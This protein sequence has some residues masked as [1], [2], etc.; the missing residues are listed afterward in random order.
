MNKTPEDPSEHNPNFVFGG[1][2]VI[3]EE[4]WS[5]YEADGVSNLIEAIPDSD[6]IELRRELSRIGHFY[7]TENLLLGDAFDADTGRPLRLKPGVGMYVTTEGREHFRHHFQ[8]AARP[9]H[10]PRLKLPDGTYAVAR[11]GTKVKVVH[12]PKTNPESS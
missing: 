1:N 9:S 8:S 6:E 5:E 11:P 7:G 2:R 3:S 10:L 12:R 4:N